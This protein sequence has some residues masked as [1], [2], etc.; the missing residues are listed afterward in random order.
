MPGPSPQPQLMQAQARGQAEPTLERGLGAALASQRVFLVQR[1]GWG[2]WGQWAWALQK[3]A[4]LAEFRGRGRQGQQQLPYLQALEDSRRF[5]L[6]K[7]G[8]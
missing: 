4:E 2:R 5:I 6:R 7:R 1:P 8:L 3:G